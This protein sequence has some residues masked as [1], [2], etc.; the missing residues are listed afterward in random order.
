MPFQIGIR[1]RIIFVYK[2]YY[3]D[4]SDLIKGTF[5]GH[6]MTFLSSYIKL[7]LKE[8]CLFSYLHNKKR[9]LEFISGPFQ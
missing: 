6:L 1:I 2:I 5:Y 4:S 9:L 8:T 3:S 7:K